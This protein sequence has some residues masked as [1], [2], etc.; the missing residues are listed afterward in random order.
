MRAAGA[1]RRSRGH[2]RTPRPRRR[3]RRPRLP[4]SRWAARA[5]VCLSVLRPA[6]DDDPDRRAPET[7]RFPGGRLA[8]DPSRKHTR[9]GAV[10]A[11][12]LA[13]GLV[14]R[15]PGCADGLASK[16]SHDATLD[17]VRL[18]P[19]C[20]RRAVGVR[21]AHDEAQAGADVASA[22]LVAL[23]GGARNVTAAR[24]HLDLPP[25]DR[26]GAHDRLDADEADG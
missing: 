8:E 19:D 23:R 1:S 18:G 15:D 7:A 9:M 2:W 3:S 5:R 20:G 6:A 11:A 12:E 24:E 25:R 10:D 13:A 21:R 14:E 16:A 22:R 4:I 26:G 17:G